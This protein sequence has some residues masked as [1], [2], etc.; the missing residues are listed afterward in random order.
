[1]STTNWCAEAD[2]SVYDQCHI[3]EM[4]GVLIM[5]MTFKRRKLYNVEAHK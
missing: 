2:D 5:R 4:K 3:N 1:M